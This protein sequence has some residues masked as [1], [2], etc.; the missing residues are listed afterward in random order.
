M[1]TLNRM[2]LLSIIPGFL[3]ALLLSIILLEMLDLFSNIY[4]YINND[5]GIKNILTI[6]LYYIPKCI[7]YCL[8]FALLFSVSFSLGTYQSRNE[9]LAVFGA[10][11]SLSRFVRPVVFLGLFLSLFLFFFEDRVVIP[12]FYQKNSL[13]RNYLN[14]SLSLSSASPTVLDDNNRII[15]HAEYYN[16]ERSYLS[17]LIIIQRDDS[18]RLQRRINAKWAEFSEGLWRLQDCRIFTYL[19]DSQRITEEKVQN[20]SSPEFNANPSRFRRLDRTIEEIPLIEAREVIDSLIKSGLPYR[21][22]LLGYYRRFSFSLTPFIVSFLACSLGGRFKKNIL[23]LCLLGSLGL[24][25]VFYVMQMILGIMAVNN[26]MAPLSAAWIPLV[27][28]T[29]VGEFLFWTGRR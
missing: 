16:D 10:G 8:P 22:E 26:Y 1:K 7:S 21:R 4:R 15:Y 5:V 3:G 9:L 24:A 29:I 17:N 6:C 25:V 14:M 11:V 20:F 18:G 28:F 27:F 2:F 12:S 19:P 13:T 23:L